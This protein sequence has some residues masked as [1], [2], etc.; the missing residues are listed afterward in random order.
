LYCEKEGL[1]SVLRSAGWAERHDC[2]LMSA[3][4]FASRAARDVL[5]LVAETEED[6]FFFCIHD[7]DAY[8]TKIWEALQEG[9]LARP[10][11]KARVVNLGLEPWEAIDMGLAVEKFA[12]T[13]G[14]RP[15][16]GY[17]TRHGQEWVEWLQSNR[18][19]LNAMTGPQFLDWLDA[20]MAEHTAGKVVPP[21]EVIR[22]EMLAAAEATVRGNLTAEA[23]R[24]AKV[25]E[26]YASTVESL[27]PAVDAM[28]P[29]MRSI[30]KSGLDA[31]PTTYWRAVAEKKGR[32]VAG[33]LAAVDDL[34]L[35]GDGGKENR[36]ARQA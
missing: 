9:T 36:V 6:I 16:A 15:V 21:A 28:T 17:V 1:I 32:A 25:E 2:A 4:G 7:A 34:R 11:R 18:I 3:K 26:R 31:E 13:S 35:V 30:V 5:D 12:K 23:L 22:R 24:A 10:G 27:L 20:K 33:E 14:K 19:E 8:G 29:R